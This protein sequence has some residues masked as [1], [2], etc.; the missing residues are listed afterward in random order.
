[1]GKNNGGN[2]LAIFAMIIAIGSLGLSGYMFLQEEPLPEGEEQKITEIW[3]DSRE[4]GYSCSSSFTTVTDLELSIT[5]NAGEK[6]FIQFNGGFTI[7]PILAT[8][9]GQIR[10]QIDDATIPGTILGFY[11]DG[12]ASSHVGSVS[13]QYV[14]SGLTAGTHK[15]NIQAVVLGGSGTIENMNLFVYTFI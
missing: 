10:L 9:G 7:T 14:A 1:M 8:T 15:I 2:V 5:V 13:L 4:S 12:S 11:T 6:V 3:S